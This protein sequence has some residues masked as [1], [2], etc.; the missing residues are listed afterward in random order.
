MPNNETSTN[1]NAPSPSSCQTTTTAASTS[2]SSGL[3]GSAAVVV[4]GDEEDVPTVTC[5]VIGDELRSELVPALALAGCAVGL[6]TCEGV[7]TVTAAVDW[8]NP[9][10][11]LGGHVSTG[12]ATNFA[13]N[14]QQQQQVRVRMR[15]RMRMAVVGK[16][17][18][19]VS[20][21]GGA[22]GIDKCV[23]LAVCE[24]PSIRF[25]LRVD[26]TLARLYGHV[27][28]ANTSAQSLRHTWSKN[29]LLVNWG[30][31]YFVKD[32]L[33]TGGGSVLGAA[34]LLCVHK[35]INWD[36]KSVRESLMGL[37]HA[38]LETSG[39]KLACA[40]PQSAEPSL[41]S[42]SATTID[43]SDMSP[44]NVRALL[45]L[46]GYSQADL[47]HTKDYLHEGDS[48][49]NH[50]EQI[51]EHAAQ[52][53]IH[54]RNWGAVQ[55]LIMNNA[56]KGKCINLTALSM[57]SIPDQ[58][59]GIACHSLDLRGNNITWLPQWLFHSEIEEVLLDENSPVL[60]SVP[61]RLMHVSWTIL[62]HFLMFGEVPVVTPSYKMI[63]V[64]EPNEAKAAFLK[65]M[66]EKKNT[67]HVQKQNQECL[68]IYVQAEIKLLKK[69]LNTWTVWNLGG[70]RE[71]P[72]HE[73]LF[74]SKSVFVVFFDA[75]LPKEAN[76]GPQ[77]RL[78]FWLSEISRCHKQFNVRGKARVL[79]FGCGSD[80]ENPTYI[81]EKV[82]APCAWPLVGNNLD[83]IGY[84]T[85][86][87][88]YKRVLHYSKMD[89]PTFPSNKLISD[90]ARSVH[91]FQNDFVSRRWIALH[92][93]LQRISSKT[94]TLAQLKA[95]AKKH[96]VGTLHRDTADLDFSKCCE[97]L[98]DTGAITYLRGLWAHYHLGDRVVLQPSWFND[99]L[100][101]VNK[102]CVL[103][104]TRVDM[105]WGSRHSEKVV[106][107][108][109]IELGCPC[110]GELIPT[111]VRVLSKDPIVE[112]N[113]VWKSGIQFS[114]KIPVSTSAITSQQLYVAYPGTTDTSVDIYMLTEFEKNTEPDKPLWSSNPMAI[115]I[116]WLEQFAQKNCIPKFLHSFPCPKCLSKLIDARA[117]CTVDTK[118]PL[119]EGFHFFKVPEG[120]SSVELYSGKTGEG[121][122]LC[123][124]GGESVCG[125]S[126]ACV[127]KITDVAPELHFIVP[128]CCSPQ[129]INLSSDP[130]VPAKVNSET[131]TPEQSEVEVEHNA[132]C[133][134]PALLSSFIQI[135]EHPNVAQVCCAHAATGHAL[136]LPVLTN[137]SPVA[138]PPHILGILNSF[139]LNQKNG[140]IE[141]G[142]LLKTLSVSQ[143]LLDVVLPVSLRT[144][145][146][147]GVA[148]AINY[149]HC[150][151]PHFCIK[152]ELL[153]GGYVL[154]TSLNESGSG[155]WAKI[156]PFGTSQ[157]S[158]NN[159]P[160]KMSTDVWNF[161]MLVH[162]LMYYHT[163]G[164]IDLETPK[165]EI[166]EN[167][168]APSVSRH[169]T[170]PATNKQHFRPFL[171]SNA[172]TTQFQ[173]ERVGRSQFPV[174]STPVF[175]PAA[176]THSHTPTP[177]SAQKATE[178]SSMIQVPDWAKQVM[179]CCWVAN[180]TA[181][182][183]MQQVLAIWNHFL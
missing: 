51:V 17:S 13:H 181:R 64:G 81:N 133:V 53:W 140:V 182:P 12:S 21:E 39:N 96:Q 98:A 46:V 11:G 169:S 136:V 89:E 19:V 110:V 74:G 115:V 2:T 4:G 41:L 121:Y 118:R 172:T 176:Q 68:P 79:L 66:M 18:D 60:S 90:I 126:E 63:L 50:C 49:L 154:V 56:L 65:S 158:C 42:P 165:N 30:R 95:L 141:L 75:T 151:N 120:K 82:F 77:Q 85:D 9:D 149:L 180:P 83:F 132:P 167:P 119:P 117:D 93:T 127:V 36:Q 22:A 62:K 145:I 7:R 59:K 25:C 87:Y 144:K 177:Q 173:V 27:C 171:L 131:S 178:P 183:S 28:A 1:A 160:A 163:A 142:N 23:I 37:V 16:E 164:F 5:L 125:V 45:Q 80:Q 69:K 99:C 84:L 78:S 148:Q 175:P 101:T 129:T 58:M 130:G 143:G 71:R 166:T 123:P 72:F 67:L 52:R 155:P 105:L 157:R 162:D 104:P 29:V 108:R 73:C 15:M 168:K 106:N 111:L 24:E 156:A 61:R 107:G 10:Y 32:Y 135:L 44:S 153:K 47:E 33:P 170:S 112:I 20:E 161:G 103:Y 116:G 91:P 8:P 43:I 152:G 124:I 14:P 88:P 159:Y 97:F 114:K 86:N 92:E 55:E 128:C 38:I 174:G 57:G 113:T 76:T 40:M 147:W 70:D 137:V 31:P 122:L 138:V 35:I 179:T 48:H 139:G 94:I 146:L 109:S 6:E 3:R 54:L 102:P 26:A 100:Q 34:F 134:T 150:Q